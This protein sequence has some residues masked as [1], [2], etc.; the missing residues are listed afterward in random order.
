MPS[1]A[2]AYASHVAQE[3]RPSP[4]VTITDPAH[5]ARP[6]DLL[7]AEP[8]RLARGW[9]L[10]AGALLVAGAVVVVGL[11]VRERRATAAEE[12]RLEAIVDV[13]VQA[14]GGGSSYDLESRRATLENRLLLL[15]A[16]PR[17]LVVVGASVGEYELVPAEVRVPSGGSAPLLLERS[18]LCSTTTPPPVTPSGDL[19]LQLRTRT[20]S[21]IVEVP[22]AL[23][24]G[25]DEAA[26]ACGF[27]P[28][29]EAVFLEIFGLPRPGGLAFEVTTRSVRPVELLALDVGPG[30]GGELRD[31]DGSAVALPLALP[32]GSGPSV[33]GSSLTL[34]LEVTDCAVARNR[35]RVGELQLVVRLRDERGV[36]E[37][38]EAY[39]G[40]DLVVA[41]LDDVC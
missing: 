14:E 38:T 5:R 20:G 16:G 6:A 17:D 41:L 8:T 11:E 15:N 32:T 26:R 31:P 40:S 23:P 3:P 9:L 10:A 24:V 4:Q 13:S 21:R 19:A 1:A 25:R 29:E 28:L 7:E 37:D 39:Y 33:V 35:S 22:F 34:Q 27:V 36:T 2:D 18:V 30:L 12:R